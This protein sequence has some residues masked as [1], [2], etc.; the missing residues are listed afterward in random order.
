MCGSGFNWLPATRLNLAIPI[1]VQKRARVRWVPL[2]SPQVQTFVILLVQEKPHSPAPRLA[3]TWH[4]LHLYYCEA[5]G[6]HMRAGE[7]LDTCQ[8]PESQLYL[9]GT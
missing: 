9:L 4:L 2:T 1:P 8:D 3:R 6:E 5:G 7:P